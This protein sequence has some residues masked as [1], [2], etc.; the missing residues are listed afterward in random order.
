MALKELRLK[1]RFTLCFT[2]K[3]EELKK[4]EVMLTENEITFSLWKQ[5]PFPNIIEFRVDVNLRQAEIVRQLLKNITV[6]D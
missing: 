6:Y 5:L 4:V 1:E 2:M 3:K